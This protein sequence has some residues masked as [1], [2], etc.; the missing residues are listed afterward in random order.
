MCIAEGSERNHV[1]SLWD[2]IMCISEGSERNHV[3]SLCVILKV[4]NRTV[5]HHN[6]TS[7]CVSLKVLNRTMWHHNVDLTLVLEHAALLVVVYGRVMMNHYFR[8]LHRLRWVTLNWFKIIIIIEENV[9]DKK[10]VFK[11]SKTWFK[12]DSLFYNTF[13]EIGYES[14]SECGKMMKPVSPA[15][16]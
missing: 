1:A 13:D 2:I 10:V 4:L 11:W 9:H 6:G 3:T 12:I 7:L 16:M 14:I 8:G 15:T 5:W